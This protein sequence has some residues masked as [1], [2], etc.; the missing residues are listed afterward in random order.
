MFRARQSLKLQVQV[1]DNP[2]RAAQ[3]LEQHESVARVEMTGPRID[4]TLKAGVE[5]YSFLPS[6]LIEAGY[7]LTLFR[8][9]EVNLETA[10]ML[11]TK[12]KQQ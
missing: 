3:W 7:R 8:E 11:L 12:G 1:R 2:E 9:E 10:F 4:V 5:D 6:L